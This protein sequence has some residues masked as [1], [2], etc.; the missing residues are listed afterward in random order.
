MDAVSTRRTC[1]LVGVQ[2]HEHQQQEDQRNDTWPPPQAS[3]S[4]AADINHNVEQVTSF[5][6]LGVGVTINDALKWDEHIAAVTSKAAA[7]L[8]WFLKKLKRAG[9]SQD[10]LVYYQA[11]IRPVRALSGIQVLQDNSRS[12]LIQSIDGPVKLSLTT[13]H[14]PAPFSG[15]PVCTI[16]VINCVRDFSTTCS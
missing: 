14:T 15:Y 6:L 2:L 4:P 12:T 8:Q 9:V 5:K 16:N 3:A 7:K 13:G 10:D 11:V 1:C